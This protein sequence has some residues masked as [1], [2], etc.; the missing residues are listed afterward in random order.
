MVGFAVR[1]MSVHAN[2]CGDKGELLKRAGEHLMDYSELLRTEHRCLPVHAHLAL[3]KHCISHI[4][5]YKAA[6]GICVYKHHGWV[7]MTIDAAASGN[8]AF[9]STYHDEHENG[10]LAI[11]GTVVHR[12]NWEMSVFELLDLLS[13][14]MQD[15]TDEHRIL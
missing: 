6:G 1:I 5:L 2:R 15:P 14:L 9:T 7:H 3:F 10:S 12:L 11:I 13:R 8:P 4:Q